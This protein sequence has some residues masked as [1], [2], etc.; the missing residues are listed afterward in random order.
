LRKPRFLLLDEPSAALDEASE[1]QILQALQDFARNG[2]GVLAIAHREN[3][4]TIADLII[5]FA[6]AR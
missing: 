3:F 6:G 5:D 1:K 4:R 2:G